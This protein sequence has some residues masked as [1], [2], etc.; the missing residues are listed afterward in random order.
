MIG[1]DDF[2]IVRCDPA[3]TLEFTR[4]LLF[5]GFEAWAPVVEREYRLP[6]SKKYA[7]SVEPLLASF[8]F[9]RAGAHPQQCAERLDDMRL[10]YGIRVMRE[11]GRYAGVTD[12]ALDGLRATE[13]D[14]A[15]FG[16]DNLVKDDNFKVGDTGTVAAPTL[17]GILCTIV[18]RS[19]S[20]LIVSLEGSN[21]PLTIKCAMFIP[22]NK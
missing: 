19:K 11:N 3:K 2:W 18:S 15:T 16:I 14:A 4:S 12:K 6:R 17:G 8:I 7:R 1:T 5:E 10:L 20:N 22:T 21:I 13:R 9:V